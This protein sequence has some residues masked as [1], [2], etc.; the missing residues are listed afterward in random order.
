MDRLAAE[1]KVDPPETLVLFRHQVAVEAV[2]RGELREVKRGEHGDMPTF[3]LVGEQSAVLCRVGYPCVSQVV[4]GPR[5]ELE[6]V[7]QGQV[8]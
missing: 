7:L 6:P 1:S 4:I 2:R 5:I 8:E 3:V